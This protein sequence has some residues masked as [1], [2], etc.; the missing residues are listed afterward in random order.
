MMGRSGFKLLLCMCCRAL[1]VHCCPVGA[2]PAVGLDMH[3]AS[4]AVMLTLVPNLAH[5]A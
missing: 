5:C 1:G 3:A 2:S 4:S